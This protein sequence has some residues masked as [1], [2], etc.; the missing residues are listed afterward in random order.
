MAKTPL[1][2]Q[3]C[4]GRRAAN[5]PAASAA[6][7]IEN[8]AEN[9]GTEVAASDMATPEPRAALYA[10]IYRAAQTQM[11][12]IELVQ[13][14]LQPTHPE[15]SERT[16]RILATLNKTLLEIA[17]MTKPDEG[18]PP[19]E[20]DDDAIPRDIDEFRRELARRLKAFIDEKSGNSAR[21]PDEFSA[22]T[23]VGRS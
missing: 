14:T 5:G 7:A 13:K 6:P 17:A 21:G 22:G 18:A 23:Q 8:V 1:Q 10:R 9:G 3:C 11:D 12:K 15:Q 20:A 19:D 16:V 2:Q 4:R